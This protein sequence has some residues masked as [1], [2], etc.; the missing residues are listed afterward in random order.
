MNRTADN[1]IDVQW[2]AR[3]AHRLDSGGRMRTLVSLEEA[4]QELWHEPTVARILSRARLP[5][6]G[7]AWARPSASIDQRAP[8]TL[9]SCG[10]REIAQR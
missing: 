3:C 10:S 8:P 2:V 9:P 1:L 7:F 4:A 6:N 5:K